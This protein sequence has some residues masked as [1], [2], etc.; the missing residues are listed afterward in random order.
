MDRTQSICVRFLWMGQ[1]L[2]L[3]SA[4]Q[5]LVSI[6]DPTMPCCCHAFIYGGHRIVRL[7]MWP[8]LH[9]FSIRCRPGLDPVQCFSKYVGRDESTVAALGT[10]PGCSQTFL[11]SA[12]AKAIKLEE[13][14]YGLT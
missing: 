1:H 14:S 8:F 6:E 9:D 5:R 12:T 4:S 2:A 7:G 10:I 3:H 13:E 11:D